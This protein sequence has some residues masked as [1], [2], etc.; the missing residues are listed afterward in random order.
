MQARDIMSVKVISV[1]PKQTLKEVMELL[2]EHKVSGLPVVD[3]ENKVIGI[4]SER[5]IVRYCEKEK[6]IPFSSATGWLASHAH[7]TDI[8]RLK[9]GVEMLA[10]ITVEKVMRSEV[11]TAKDDLSISKAAKIMNRHRINRIPIVDQENRLAG[12]ITRD[13]LVNFLAEKDIYLR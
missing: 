4:L 2:F 7:L 5:D 1:T 13:D 6:A 8:A 11:I 9:K 12:I 3:E 10:K